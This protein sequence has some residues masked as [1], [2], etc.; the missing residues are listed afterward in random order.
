M[1]RPK[2]KRK[3]YRKIAKPYGVTAK[4]VE[5]EIAAAIKTAFEQPGGSPEKKLLLEMFPDGEIPSNEEFINKLVEIYI[6]AIES[7]CQPPTS[8]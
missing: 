7:E 1:K 8:G 5:T 4:E 2:H 6:D 3:N